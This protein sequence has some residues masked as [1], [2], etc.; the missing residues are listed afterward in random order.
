MPGSGGMP[1]GGRDAP[2]GAMGGGRRAMVPP[3][4]LHPTREFVLEQTAAAVTFRFASKNA[5]KVPTNGK[6]VTAM[7]WPDVGPLEVSAHWTEAG[8]R[9]ERQ[10]PEGGSLVEVLSRSPGSTRLIS[11]V[12]IDGPR[13]RRQVR[14]V[15]ERVSPEG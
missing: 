5:V 1:R 9:L 8:L 4:L 15:Y 14:R 3:Q 7:Q 2:P 12:E 11:T 6:K 13:G 10:L